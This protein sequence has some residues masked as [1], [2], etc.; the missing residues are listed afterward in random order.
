MFFV[1]EMKQTFRKKNQF[2]SIKVLKKCYSFWKHPLF[3][4]LMILLYTN[5]SI[6]T[7][8]QIDFCSKVLIQNPLKQTNKRKSRFTSYHFYL[9]FQEISG[10]KSAFS[11]PPAS[12]WKV[13]CTR[14]AST[15]SEWSTFL[16]L[17]PIY[18]FVFHR[19]I[20]LLVFTWKHGGTL[21]FNTAAEHWD[22]F[23]KEILMLTNMA[24]HLR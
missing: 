19:L 4:S 10:M 13:T 21:V 20:I 5:L 14:T 11:H 23:Q 7:D 2:C 24:R 22:C 17:F 16:Q 1:T 6:L 18:K 9:Y 3:V 12:L 15:V 8:S